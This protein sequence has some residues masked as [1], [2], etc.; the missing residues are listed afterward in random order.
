MKILICVDEIKYLVKGKI[1]SKNF[2]F[3]YF[4]YFL[5]YNYIGDIYDKI[6]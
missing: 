4:V 5:R 6:L 1:E 2:I 3:L